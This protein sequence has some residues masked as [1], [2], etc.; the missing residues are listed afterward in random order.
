MT[1]KEAVAENLAQLLALRSHSWLFFQKRSTEVPAC[2][3]ELHK[4]VALCRMLLRGGMTSLI[5]LRMS[6]SALLLR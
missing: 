1:P 4:T 5:F 6:R 2:M 3:S